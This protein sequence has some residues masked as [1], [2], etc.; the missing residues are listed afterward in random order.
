MLHPLS[1][2]DVIQ[3]PCLIQVL[4]SSVL[5]PFTLSPAL[6]VSGQS[7]MSQSPFTTEIKCCH[8]S[9]TDSS[10]IE[11]DQYNGKFGI[12]E[13]CQIKG[14]KKKKTEW[15][16]ASFNEQKLW[17]NS[18]GYWGNRKVLAKNPRLTHKKQCSC[19]K[20]PLWHWATLTLNPWWHKGNLVN[21]NHIVGINKFNTEWKVNTLAE[22]IRS[23][24]LWITYHRKM[25][26]FW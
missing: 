2:F 9:C 4:W 18:T 1:Q 23:F 11:S 17:W 25:L 24:I 13:I 26:V 6:L 21:L 16:S 15:A 10:S 22:F 3:A 8:Q 7:Y 19:G 5:G 12:W 20:A 14:A